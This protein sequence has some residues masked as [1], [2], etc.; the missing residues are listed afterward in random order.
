MDKQTINW[1]NR[2]LGRYR[3]QRLLGRGAMGEVWQAEDTQYHRLVA[4]KLL[5]AVLRSEQH[6]LRMFEQEARAAATLDHPHILHVHDFGET[7]IEDGEVIT[8][9]VM[10]C[11][12]GGTLRERLRAANSPLS[13]AEGLHYL[14][15]A[16]QAIDYAHSQQVLHRD[17]KPSNMLLNE[18]W[19]L[20]ADFGLARLLTSD[21]YRSRTTIGS[22]TPEY[23]APEQARGRAEAASDRYSLAIVAYQ[24]FTGQ[25]PFKD[26]TPYDILL[27]QISTP[28][29]PARRFNPSIPAGVERV[30]FRGMAKQAAYRYPSCAAFI[31]D[32]ERTWRGDEPS[33]NIP[34]LSQPQQQQGQYTTE[35]I[36]PSS[37]TM[38]PMSLPPAIQQQAPSSAP[39]FPPVMPQPQSSSQAATQYNNHPEGMPLSAAQLQDYNTPTYVS[40]Y[41]RPTQIYP[42]DQSAP[43]EQPRKVGRRA[44]LIGGV[45]AATAVVAGGTWL[46]I[47]HNQP[48]APLKPTPTP[49]PIPG[50]RVIMSGRP[51]LNLTG[52]SDTI[53]NTLWDPK[54]RYLATAGEDS[55]MM[56]WDLG[57]LLQKPPTA[58]QSVNQPLDSWK[59]KNEMFSNDVA[60]SPD[61]SM[62]AATDGETGM[63]FLYDP[64]PPKKDPKT[65]VD[66]TLDKSDPF[67]LPSYRSPAWQPKGNL[68]AAI[69]SQLGSN[70]IKITLWQNDNFSTPTASLTYTDPEEKDQPT[71]FVC[72]WS[73]DGAYL[74]GSTSNAKVIVWDIKSRQVK[75][76]LKL[77]D[78]TKGKDIPIVYRL[79]LTWSPADPNMLA[80][81]WADSVVVCDINQPQPLF[82]LGT[83]DPVPLTPP[84]DIKKGQ[85]WFPL[86]NGIAWSP[87]GR[88]I[89]ASYARSAR[90]YIWDLKG[91]SSK[92]AKD[93]VTQIQDFFFPKEGEPGHSNT[94]VDLSWSP[95]GRY[96]ATGSFDKTAIVWLVDQAST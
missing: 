26:G 93:G 42:P 86:V 30:L 37:P 81:W 20:L 45:T 1:Q 89:A 61:S 70:P 94:V 79:A 91:G 63:F 90:A 66:S 27:K 74:A 31:E 39:S 64:Q 4:V 24:V 2:L 43:G 96:L 75:T 28:P 21:T 67:N 36:P 29:P 55:R 87:N 82:Q 35:M 59:L 52:H 69:E 5:P 10:P 78:R 49:T 33:D 46:F 57:Q 92:K 17:I 41:A 12:N 73:A 85:D 22:G 19:L 38:A 62:L 32:L 13:A 77:P 48:A 44:M 88:Y 60:W 53:N 3:L 11:V 84:K 15:Q 65:V 40:N 7:E 9:I 50:P 47:T 68:L 80:V 23:M 76:V 6:Y 58:I 72:A 56:V 14:K 83:D 25:L 8:Y 34:V 18:Q 95:D 71:L 54:G 51:V 16:A